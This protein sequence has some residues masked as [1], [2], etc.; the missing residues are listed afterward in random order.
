MVFRSW[1]NIYGSKGDSSTIRFQDIS[2]IN[3]KDYPS[4]PP[5]L[6]PAP[7][8][9]FLADEIQ[10]VRVSF[11]NQRFVRCGVVFNLSKG[12]LGLLTV[13]LDQ[14]IF[15]GNSNIFS[16][17]YL[18]SGH[19]VNN[20]SIT[21]AFIAHT[22]T[23]FAPFWEISFGLPD[24]IFLLSDSQF[25]NNSIHS[26]TN[27]FSLSDPLQ[28][29]LRN[30]IF[31]HNSL[32]Q[33]KTPACFTSS[34]IDISPMVRPGYYPYPIVA[35]GNEFLDNGCILSGTDSQSSSLVPLAFPAA[36]RSTL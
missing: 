7:I 21:S 20:V 28:V 27:L 2:L 14:I 8:F 5:A 35:N 36:S 6:S 23:S 4:S 26:Q 17:S 19:Q 24:A 31:Q 29:E 11:T 13:I 18:I 32:D 3:F 9:N 33:S 22:D 15:A 30:N 12:Y 1:E 16:G 10:L 25:F 34:V